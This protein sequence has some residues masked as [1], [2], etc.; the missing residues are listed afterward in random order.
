MK[1]ISDVRR[2]HLINYKVNQLINP[3][4]FLV[5]NLFLCADFMM[6]KVIDY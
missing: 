5:I 1:P 6:N 3:S 4:M 2:V